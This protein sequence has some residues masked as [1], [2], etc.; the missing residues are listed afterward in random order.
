M[1]STSDPIPD[2]DTTQPPHRQAANFY[3]E[4]AT[5]INGEFKVTM[6]HPKEEAPEPLVIT[7]DGSKA[8]VKKQHAGA[9]SF[10]TSQRAPTSDAARE[11]GGVKSPQQWVSPARCFLLRW[12]DG[13]K[14]ATLASL[15]W[16][17]LR[18]NKRAGHQ[19]T[20]C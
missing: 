8:T 13:E 10:I 20:T 7:I 15:A 3:K 14:Q 16:N 18:E 9:A 4:V 12:G 17:K 19:P 11:A 6:E 2:E 5:D 1:V